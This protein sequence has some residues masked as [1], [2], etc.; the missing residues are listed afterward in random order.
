MRRTL[1][2]AT[3]VLILSLGVSAAQGMPH[4]QVGLPA[5]AELHEAT[6]ML[7]TSADGQPATGN[8]ADWSARTLRREIGAPLRTAFLLGFAGV[9]IG[10]GAVGVKS[11]WVAE[12]A[13]YAA[14]SQDYK[15]SAPGS[16]RMLTCLGDYPA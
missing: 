12:E 2:L 14:L 11:L 7:R 9:V 3:A 16:D 1:L 13:E 8:A 6:A 15:E 5:V 4:S 10:L